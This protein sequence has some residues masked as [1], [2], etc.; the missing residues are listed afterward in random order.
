MKR[1]RSRL[2]IPRWAFLAAAIGLAGFLLVFRPWSSADDRIRTIVEGL[3]DGPV[4]QERGA[5]DS[6]DVPRARQV[7]GDRAIVAVVLGAG[8]LPASD[9][10]NGPDYAM[11]ERIAARVPTNMVILFA[12]GEDGEY[13]SSYCTGPDFPVPAKPGASLGEFEM[14]V[15]AAAERAWQYRATPANLTP[16]IEEF[17]LTFDA[18][19]AE[20]YGELPRRGPMPDTLAR[21]QIALACAGMVAGSVAF[22][23]LLRTAALAL[24]KRRRAERAL[25]RRR[26]EA[27]TRLSRL[28]EEILHPGDSTAAATTAREYT[29]VLRLLESA[30]EPHEL[31]E[32]ERRLTEL[33]RVLVR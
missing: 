31:A 5:P 10:V 28:A 30:R 25:A 3:R 11:C 24:R 21:G 16:E 26:R 22:F 4:Y 32:V 15:V 29:E 12:T 19:A 20:Y 18:E 17:V 7:I 14:S 1:S 23:L 9:H 8:P 27:E 33:E 6:V 2:G 13:G